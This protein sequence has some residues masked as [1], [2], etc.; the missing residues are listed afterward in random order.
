M[1]RF[2]PYYMR[3]FPEGAIER[4]PL[5]FEAF[6]FSRLTGFITYY[7]DDPQVVKIDR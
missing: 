4:V 6:A 3:R 2:L 7:V 5:K 1:T